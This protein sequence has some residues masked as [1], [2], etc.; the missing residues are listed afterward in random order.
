VKILFHSNAPWYPSGYGQQVAL[1]APR[2]ARH[3]DVAISAFHGLQGGRLR[4]SGLDVYPALGGTYGNECILGHAESFFGRVR[5]GL[6]LTLLDVPALD[7]AV[8]RRLDVACWV[9]VDHDPAPPL[10]KGFLAETAAIPV[11][12]SRFAQDRL[13]GVDPLYVPHGI[14][15]AVFAPRP[16]AEARARVG[17]PTGA[18]VVGAVAMN[19]G[20]PS[21]KSLPQIV[22]AFA[23]FRQDHDDALL[24]LH[25]ELAGAFQEGVDLP[26]LLQAFGLDPDVVRF[27]DQYRYQF[28]PFTPEHMADV[29][30]S[31]DVLLNPAMGEG[32]GLPVLEAQACGVPVVVTDFTAMSE[33]CGA[34]WKVGFDRVRTPM[35]AWQA[36][37]RVDEVVAALEECL[38]LSG[39]E[40]RELS[41]RAREHAV[42][43]DADR[44]LDE[45]WL[46]ALAEIEQRLAD[47]EP[48]VVP[49]R[50]A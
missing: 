14:D 9:P 25:T 50:A 1:F 47:R 31:F 15:T 7:P 34:G 4:W 43:Y 33:V 18:F 36:W 38:E 46:P 45:H 3:A 21:R 44:V 35:R 41:T 17:L 30:S 27:P 22:E 13:S 11:A 49:A 8:W 42:E 24:Y 48:L 6:V 20:Y 23:A 29:Y 16:Q 19:K 10:V 37:P 2:L 26:P 40:R 5:G 39:N 32:F 28:D 12:I